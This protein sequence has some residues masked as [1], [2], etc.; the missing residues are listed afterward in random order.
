[1]EIIFVIGITAVAF[2]LGRS[3]RDLFKKR[4][5]RQKKARRKGITKLFAAIALL[6]VTL[7][8]ATISLV[9]G[10]A[11]FHNQADWI[12]LILYF[13]IDGFAVYIFILLMDFLKK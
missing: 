2:I 11:V 3:I 5:V 10:I 7:L 8:I 1:M 6:V 12:Q 13:I 4:P 9:L